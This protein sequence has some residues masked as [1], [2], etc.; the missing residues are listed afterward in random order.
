M[1]NLYKDAE[2]LVAKMTIEEVAKQ[3]K[4][5]AEAVERLDIPAYNWWNEALHGVA[6]AG[7]ATVFP[8]AIGLAAMF[9][10]ELLFKIA[11]V[12]ATEGRAKYNAQA[13]EE[14]RDIYKG[15]TFWSPNINI[16][17]DARWGRG[18]ETYGEDPYLTSRLGVS[19]IK[20]LQGIDNYPECD[21]LK[22]AA[23]AKHYAVHSG[24]EGERHHFNAK[25]TKKDM[26][27]TY[28]PAFEAAVR[29]GKVESVMGAYNRTNGEP[30][31]G[32]KT[33][34]KD[35]LRGK[36]GFK[37][38]FVS[39]CWAIKDFHEN[40]K[41]TNSP[42]ESAALALNNGCDLNCGNTYLCILAALKDKLIKEEDMRKACVRLMATRMKLGILPRTDEEATKKI[43]EYDGIGFLECDTP[44]HNAVSLKAAE[45]SIVL[46]K[47]N[48]VLPLKESEYKTIGV[49][50]PT[51]DIRS[52][53]EGNY[54]GTA[55]EYV[56]NLN[57]IRRT[58]KSR[59]VYS[60]GCHLFKDRISNLAKAND[61]MG[62]AVAVVKNTDITILCVGLDAT[63]EGEEGDTG[64]MFASGDKI[65]LKLPDSQLNLCKNVM[66]AAKENGK[67]VVV[68]LNAGSAI[69]I[70][71][72]DAEADA[73]VDCFY[74]GGQGGQALANV[75]FGKVSP[76]GRLPITFY[77]D[78]E[79]PEFTDY[80]MKNRTYRYFKGETLYPFGYGL[81]YSKFDV[82]ASLE[83][84]G[85]VP[86]GDADYDA[87]QKTSVN[88]K[89]D[90]TNTGDFDADEVILAYVDK[91]PAEKLSNGLNDVTKDKLDPDD[92][93]IKSLCAFKRVSLNKGETKSVT[94]PV[95]AHSLTTV[96]E[97][98]TR[99][100]LKGEYKFSVGSTM[101][102][103]INL[104]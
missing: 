12:I 92:Q 24:P 104:Q 39:D 40:H 8:Q 85:F 26:E 36:W 3:L 81:S 48:G 84:A 91:C 93:P 63:I 41:I 60:E 19:F 30:C 77:K 97:D 59:I 55:S 99:A 90:I 72:L 64:N 65:S 87:L 4:Y 100:F 33:L 38:H 18:H 61:R 82:N 27:E 101:I 102:G 57:G 75:L 62:E 47:N 34:I 31:C 70:S 79:Q 9:D 44:E 66:K 29:E 2:E 11:E 78:G 7:T 69:D 17:R 5:D 98:G 6:R 23:C 53:L 15:L 1:S 20:G 49:V 89:V 52:V 21:T 51:A 35:I 10:D 95:S 68:V 46:L 80:S 37:G 67:K 86:G 14:D 25:A 73:I 45:E 22:A 28:L 50:G 74:S 96:L 54:N 58:A 43:K 94:L 83:T 76:S 16:F 71:E 103:T 32:S 88:V 42:A 56:T 13:K